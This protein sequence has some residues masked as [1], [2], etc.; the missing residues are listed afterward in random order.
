MEKPKF[1]MAKAEYLFGYSHPVV[2]KKKLKWERPEEFLKKTPPL[3][4]TLNG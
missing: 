4:T 3:H 2:K 1:K